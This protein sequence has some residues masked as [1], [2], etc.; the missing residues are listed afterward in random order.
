VEKFEITLADNWEKQIVPGGV[1]IFSKTGEVLQVHIHSYNFNEAEDKKFLE[2]LVEKYN[3]SPIVQTV[4]AGLKFITTTYTAYGKEQSLYSAVKN[5]YQIKIQMC[6][7]CYETNADIK[8]M[9]DSLVFN[10]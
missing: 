7:K 6:G 1:Q 2:E 10:V 5:G 9:V 8:A 3:G 4:L